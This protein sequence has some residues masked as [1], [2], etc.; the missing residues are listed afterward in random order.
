VRIGF[1]L[2]NNKQGGLDTF[3]LQLL[4]NWP[5]ADD[6]VLFCN[7]SHPG[8]KYLRKHV[9][10]SVKII[11]YGF[12][13]FQDFENRFNK[14]PTIINYFLKRFF[15]ATGI[16]YQVKILKRIFSGANLERL[17]VI[18]GG[19]PAG[20]ACQA[21]TI[22]WY[23]LFPDHPA[24]HNFHNF[25]VPL[26]ESRLR[27]LKEIWIDRQV[28]KA[29]QGFVSVSSSCKDSLLTR[30]ALRNARSDFIYNGIAPLM[31]KKTSSLHDELSLVKNTQII[32]MLAV[33]EPRKGH[34][35]IV[36]VM[37]LLVENCPLAQ[38]VIC[39]YGSEEEVE[40]VAKLR[41]KSQVASHI[42]LLAHQPNI[43]NLLAQSQ[44]LV[45]PSQAYESF[46]YTALEAMC[47][48]VP[49]VVTNV[50]GLPEV[51]ENG[52][53]GYVVD[54]YDMVSFASHIEEL[55][56]DETLRKNMGEQGKLRY[57]KYFSAKRMASEYAELVRD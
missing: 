56:C 13:I 25:A 24:W 21:A 43:T 10:Q 34:E 6:L 38:L 19:Y 54:R 51:V 2:Q 9:P 57:E 30:S 37:E 42:H 28:N 48:M 32:M 52:V 45:V 33:Y 16:F 31:P 35:F 39:G 27:R 26:P 4:Q 49:L 44:V 14:W 36:N 22:A 5:E 23:K 3:V 46:G 7:S 20:D 12:L 17:M 29:V 1:F 18:N 55:L 50:G 8:L 41:R 11:S 53:C 15:W 40:V 47:C